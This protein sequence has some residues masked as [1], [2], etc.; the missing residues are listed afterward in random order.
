MII[1]WQFVESYEID[2]TSWSWRMMA[3]DGTIEHQSPPF[4]NYG[5]A[6]GDAIKR[7][8]QPSHQH[9]LVATR[10]TITHFRPGQPALA[11]PVGE[12]DALLAERTDTAPKSRKRV[13][14]SRAELRIVR[15]PTEINGP[16]SPEKVM[17][18]FEEE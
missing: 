2:S 8:F 13:L 11:V 16:S 1:R 4:K 5:L 14:P 10:H 9:W 12:R 15:K 7:G 17:P 3:V 6:V 18:R